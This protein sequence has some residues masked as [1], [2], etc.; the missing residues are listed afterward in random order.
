MDHIRYT[1][2]DIARQ[3][4]ISPST[5]SRALKDH[6]DISPKTKKAVV[7]LAN[8]LNYRPNAIA[9]SLRS[10]KSNIIG[11]IIP[12][13][14][15]YFF[16]TIIS[17][18]EEVAHQ[19]GYQVMICQSNEIYQREVDIA[20][21]LLSSRIDG[22]LVSITKETLQTDHFQELINQGVPI[23]FFDR[24]M[25][26]VKSDKVIVDDHDGAF[27]AVEHLIET[28]RKRIVHFAGPQN[29]LIGMNRRNGYVHAL[30]EH[31]IPVN[32]DLIINCDS[33]EKAFDVTSQ[34]LELKNPPDA[35]FAVNDLTAIGA[36]KTIKQAGLKIP[37]DIALAGFGDSLY[38]SF[39]DPSLT[40][41][42]QPGFEMGT[43]AAELLFER[44]NTDGDKFINPQLKVLKTKLIIRE[45]SVGKK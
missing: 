35:I 26:D 36:M 1:I 12:E 40:T 6:P 21:T 43:L 2:K 31:R 25:H 41:V 34:L 22:L 19:Q 16:S 13:M 5:V 33:Y 4:G 29:R 39:V 8:E 15:H 23:I 30:E 20:Y 44:L 37:E 27:K 10:R 45:S 42:T 3:L 32:K 24:M 18:I 17:G 11:V 28:G 14:V 9:L 38:A 7:D